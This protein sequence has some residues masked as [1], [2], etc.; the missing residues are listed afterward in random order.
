MKNAQ[1]TWI[2]AIIGLAAVGLVIWLSPSPNYQARG[3]LLPAQRIRPPISPNSVTLL[4]D[5]PFAGKVMGYI[6]IERH[7]P[8]SGNLAQRQIDQL[9]QKLAA[10]VG[11]NT[12]VVNNFRL[13]AVTSSRYIY[14]FQ[15][16]AY[17][18]PTIKSVLESSNR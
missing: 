18:A 13:G 7:Y 14:V 15:A 11:A 3:I 10:Q 17:Y 4:S 1:R 9:A 5:P 12:V 16:T 8:A 6:N 2:T